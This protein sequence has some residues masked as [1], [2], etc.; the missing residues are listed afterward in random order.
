[1]LHWFIIQSLQ[2]REPYLLNAF[3]TGL[4]NMCN[5]VHNIQ[6]LPDGKKTFKTE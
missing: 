1:M 5:V 2:Q 4:A 3:F 6:N